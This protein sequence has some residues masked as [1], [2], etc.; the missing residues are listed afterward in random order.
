MHIYWGTFEITRIWSLR[1]DL[2]C[3][4][5]WP[6]LLR[7]IGHSSVLLPLIRTRMNISALFASSTA[8]YALHIAKL[9][10]GVRMAAY[11]ISQNQVRRVMT[12]A[13]LFIF[14]SA[15]E[16]WKSKSYLGY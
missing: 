7:L 2:E 5:F 6:T 9:I 12:A 1:L 11:R 13:Y 14:L 3:G 10:W 15:W 8:R 16:I 4:S